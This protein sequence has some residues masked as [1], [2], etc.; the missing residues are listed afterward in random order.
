[1]S[2]ST[3]LF[4]SLQWPWEIGIITN[5]QMRKTG[6]GKG[7][8]F[9]LGHTERK[10]AQ[11]RIFRSKVLSTRPC[12]P[13]WD[14]DSWSGKRHLPDSVSLWTTSPHTVRSPQAAWVYCWGLWEHSRRESTVVIPPLWHS[15]P[16]TYWCLLA[17]VLRTD[18]SWADLTG[19]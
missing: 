9:S 11:S 2:H 8:D 5:G 1:M 14:P 16:H 4:W 15:S 3:F 18:N 12:C 10:C 7:I 17:P 13:L 19:I 6:S